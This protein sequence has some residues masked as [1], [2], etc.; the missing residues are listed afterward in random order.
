M[1]QLFVNSGIVSLRLFSRLMISFTRLFP[2]RIKILLRFLIVDEMRNDLSKSLPSPPIYLKER[3]IKNCRLIQDRGELLKYLPQNAIV[4]EIGVWEGDFAT[5]ILNV[6]SPEKLYLIDSWNHDRKAKE[7]K[8]ITENRFRNQIEAQKVIIVHDDSVNALSK[9]E[10]D[11]FDW[12]YLDSD[13]SYEYTKKELT[14]L[15]KKVKK[16]GFIAGHDYTRDNWVAMMR[17]GVVEAVNEF[18][19]NHDYEFVFLTF[20]QSM[21]FS[22]VLRKIK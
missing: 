17:L 15:N 6:T 8:V 10:D 12:V 1:K 13:H 20:E 2:E 7:R 18:C 3:H 11:F 19:T 16:N 9:F 4:S 5:Q 22:F 14:V 21:Y